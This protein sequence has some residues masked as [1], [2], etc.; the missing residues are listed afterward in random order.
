VIMARRIGVGRDEAE[1]AGRTDG[2][3]GL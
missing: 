1:R 3:A 2:Q